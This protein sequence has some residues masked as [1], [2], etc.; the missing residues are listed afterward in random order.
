MWPEMF[1]FCANTGHECNSHLDV[2]FYNALIYIVRLAQL[3]VCT[4]A[5]GGGGLF[6]KVR[7]SKE[8]LPGSTMPP[9]R[10]GRPCI[11]SVH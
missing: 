8:K 1:V 11:S 2:T 5:G 4:A 10:D 7:C 9:G 3:H 6:F